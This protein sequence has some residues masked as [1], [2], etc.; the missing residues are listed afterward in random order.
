VENLLRIATHRLVVRTPVGGRCGNEKKG[1]YMKKKIKD[2]LLVFDAFGI[3][4]IWSIQHPKKGNKD[5]Y[6][7]STDIGDE[8]WRKEITKI[9]EATDKLHSCYITI[10]GEI[11][12]IYGK[13]NRE[14]RHITNIRKVTSINLIP[15]ENNP[16]WKNWEGDK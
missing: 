16:L 10:S 14:I 8:S 11:T 15:D 12:F 2:Y 1:K 3:I 4:P 7:I 6:L 9:K 13:K 5:A